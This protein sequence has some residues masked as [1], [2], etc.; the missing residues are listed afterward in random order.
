MEIRFLRKIIIPCAGKSSRMKSSVPKQLLKINGR[1][2][3]NFLLEEVNKYFESIIIPIPK[4]KSSEELFSKNIEEHFL[5]KI[6]FVESESGAGDGQAVLDGLSS[7]EAN[8]SLIFVCWGDTFIIDSASAFE[9]HLN[10][11]EDADIF[12]PLIFDKNP[13]VKYVLKENSEFV[14]DIHLSIDNR[15]EINWEEGLADQSILL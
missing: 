12:V 7:L 8:G 14:K 5:S 11:S 1:A 2:A 15:N 6:H 9:K 3:I 10:I 4:D 13:Y